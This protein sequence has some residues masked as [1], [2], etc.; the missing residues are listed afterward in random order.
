MGVLS[1]FLASV[2]SFAD[3]VL[4]NALALV[5]VRASLERARAELRL[6]DRGAG[7]ARLSSTVEQLTNLANAN[8]GPGAESA[9][10]QTQL[11]LFR[12]VAYS[13]S[14]QGLERR[15]RGPEAA[16]RFAEAVRLFAAVPEDKLTPRDHS[17]YGVALA[18]LGRGGEARKHFEQAREAE[19]ATPEAC[20][21]LARLLLD[22]QDP[23]TAEHLLNEALQAVPADAD[24]LELLGR[25]QQLQGHP[26]AATT[27][28]Q[29]A[30][31]LLESGRAADARRVLD[32]AGTLTDDRAIQEMYAETSRLQGHYADAAREFD[33]LLAAD[34]DNPWL[35]VRRGSVRA[36]L[37]RRGPVLARPRA[38]AARADL[39]R[40]A[41][42]APDDAAILL[43]A[44][45]TA[46]QLGDPE[47]AR[48]YCDRALAT[49]SQ[50]PATYALRARAER[51]R[52]SIG[53]ALDAIRTGRALAPQDPDLLRL[54][55]QLERQAGDVT[56]AA[57]L[58]SVLRDTPEATRQDHHDLVSLLL[59][60]GKLQEAGRRRRGDEPLAG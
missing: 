54:H 56:A 42:L 7:E 9:G 34:A 10:L 13:L 59:A 11:D 24:A 21:H 49:D 26:A 20:R 52:G 48:R 1:S 8:K 15:G 22:G 55:A 39:A 18:A 5:A 57:E 4:K 23:S 40:A 29:A 60:T 33:R 31:L 41:D 30:Y 46:L 25:A 50:L 2:A 3:G 27:Y 37:A 47:G 32:I 14:G 43:L 12:A 16:A 44:G 36:A 35:L 45:Q 19:G 6:G 53:T 58:L 51:A 17:D 38:A 28:Q